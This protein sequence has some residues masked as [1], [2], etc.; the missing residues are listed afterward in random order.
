MSGIRRRGAPICKPSCTLM[1]SRCSRRDSGYRLISAGSIRYSCRDLAERGEIFSGNM[2]AVFE[3]SEAHQPERVDALLHYI[4]YSGAQNLILSSEL[5]FYYKYVVWDIARRAAKAGYQGTGDCLPGA[6]GSGR[7]LGLRSERPQSRISRHCPGILGEQAAREPPTV[8]KG[9]QEL[10][11][12][13]CRP[14][15]GEDIRPTVPARRRPVVGF[16]SSVTL[17]S[18]GFRPAPAGRQSEYGPATRVV[19]SPARTERER[20]SG[21]SGNP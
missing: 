15:G 11:S 3:A 2:Q 1:K 10:Q 7:G 21:G 14:R 6:A 13:G 18:Q 8:R 20:R 17:S 4:L 16:L 5:L 19:R 12:G 9:P